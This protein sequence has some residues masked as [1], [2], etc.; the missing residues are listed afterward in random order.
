MTFAQA[1]ARH[2]ELVEEIRSHDRAYYLEA[3]PVISDFEYDKLYREMLE[4]F[5]T[6]LIGA[7]PGLRLRRELRRKNKSRH[8]ANP[9]GV[10]RAVTTPRC[11]SGLLARAQRYAKTAATGRSMMTV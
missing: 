5:T 11:Q 2:A 4:G 3:K 7:E 10:K 6:G 9:G 8:C 1:K